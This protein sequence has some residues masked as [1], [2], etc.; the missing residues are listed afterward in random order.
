MFRHQVL[1][2]LPELLELKARS[3]LSDTDR[4]LPAASQLYYW[5]QREAAA[6]VLEDTLHPLFR[7]IAA[8]NKGIQNFLA[9]R[10]K[11]TGA[12]GGQVLYNVQ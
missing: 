11:Q 1:H 10:W 2:L 3:Q 7:S 5:P 8:L 12:L 9:K 4:P 6:G